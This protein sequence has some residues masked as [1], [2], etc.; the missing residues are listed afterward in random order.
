MELL[1]LAYSIWSNNASNT[2]IF[3]RSHMLEHVESIFHENGL[4]YKVLIDDVQQA[5]NEENPPL[6][7]DIQ[8]ELEGRKGLT[9]LLYKNILRL[10]YIIIY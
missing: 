3:I 4:S 1:S 9:F 2:D 8:Q 10:L 6:S 7:P 5:I